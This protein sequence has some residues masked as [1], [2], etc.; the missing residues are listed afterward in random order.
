MGC[1]SLGL[2][3]WVQT[4]RD[5]KNNSD[6][7]LHGFAFLDTDSKRYAVIAAMIAPVCD[8]LLL[9]LFEDDRVAQRVEILEDALGSE[10]EWLSSVHPLFWERMCAVFDNSGP[11]ALRTQCLA[12]ASSIAAFCKMRFLG[13]ARE[14]PWKLLHGGHFCKHRRADARRGGERPDCS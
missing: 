4:T 6:Y 2:S 5:D 3:R 7:Y 8:S 1:L 13:M 10:I 12:A 14:Y 11:C 9:E